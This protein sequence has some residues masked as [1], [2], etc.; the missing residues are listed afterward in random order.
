MAGKSQ[1]HSDTVL[2]LIG[3]SH[4]VGL[5]S[6]A[7]SSTDDFVSNP[8]TEIS[9]G[10]YARQAITWGSKSTDTDTHTRKMANSG[11]IT[12]GPASGAD[13]SQATHFG[14]FAALSGGQPKYTAALTAAKTVEVGD[15]AQFAAGDLVAKED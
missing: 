1:A 11:T 8:V 10:G 13:W 6:A 15:S 4:Y 9:G 5:L 7:P 14:I 3:T 12:F 2:D